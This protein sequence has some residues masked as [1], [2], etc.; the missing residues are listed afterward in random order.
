MEK[1]QEAGVDAE[2]KVWPGMGHV[3]HGDAATVPT[4]QQAINEIGA[5][6]AEKLKV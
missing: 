6:L 5:F 3:F 2:L 1:A 4:A